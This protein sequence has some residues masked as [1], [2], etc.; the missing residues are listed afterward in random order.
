[1]GE[2]SLPSLPA[3]AVAAAGT[4]AALRV[5]LASR[6]PA[7]TD[8]L[9]AVG[10]GPKRLR[11]AAATTSLAA[12]AAMFWWARPDDVPLSADSL[13]HLG[14]QQTPAAA[15]AVAV[16]LVMPGFVERVLRA[17][18]LA[19]YVRRRDDALLAWLRRIRLFVAAGRPISAAVLDAAERTTEPAFRPIAGTVNYAVT[20]GL[21]P[22]SAVAQRL[23]GTSAATLLGSVEAA[24]RS[25]AGA[26]DL[27]DGVLARVV[28][29]MV[30]VRRERIDALGRMIGVAAS[31]SAVLAG[32]VVVLAVVVTLPST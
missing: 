17:M 5:L 23:G 12:G 16:L 26:S 25:G 21:D 27:L 24:E 13:T 6:S 14:A 28:G 7:T 2:V 19:R 29:A 4:M 31:A 9:V 11:L 1:M 32:A 15:W 8:A 20:N 18:A 30:D 3:L 10:W 22:L